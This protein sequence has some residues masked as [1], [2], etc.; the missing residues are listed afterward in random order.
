MLSLGGSNEMLSTLKAAQKAKI[1]DKHQAK[2]LREMVKELNE[3]AFTEEHE[4]M[5]ELDRKIR[6][7]AAYY[8]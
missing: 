5:Q 4:S 8:R 2:R 3:A 7:A 1:V 6:E